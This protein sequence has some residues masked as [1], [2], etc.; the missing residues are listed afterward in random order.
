MLIVIIAS[1]EGVGHLK[2]ELGVASGSW[3][4]GRLDRGQLR[5]AKLSPNKGVGE[6]GLSR[7]NSSANLVE[8]KQ[9]ITW[10]AEGGTPPSPPQGNLQ[11]EEQSEQAGEET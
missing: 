4:S 1:T 9:V 6:A 11:L 2:F 3:A 5:K 8:T 10:E 7:E